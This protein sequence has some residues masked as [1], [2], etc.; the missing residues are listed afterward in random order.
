MACI[1]YWNVA[2]VLLVIYNSFSH[3]IAC[4]NRA[5]ENDGHVGGTGHRLQRCWTTNAS[6]LSGLF[7]AFFLI[8]TTSLDSD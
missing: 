2:K 6:R 8:I 7:S 1:F 5:E 4:S 3:Q